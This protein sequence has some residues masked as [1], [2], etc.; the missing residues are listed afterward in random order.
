MTKVIPSIQK[1][2]TTSPHTI[3]REQLLSTA[4]ALMAKHRIRHLPVLDGG[5]LIGMITERDIAL[6][7]G[8]KDADLER[9]KVEDA[10]SP[11]PFS[12]QPESK[13]DEVAD[14]MAQYKYGSAVVT[15]HGKVVG[16]FTAVDALAA[17]AELLRSR[18]KN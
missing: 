12:V 7:S 4:Q 15:S 18:L 1:Y 6:V 3:G 14:E 16:I 8:L 2:M 13:L 5:A 10:M 17:F 11:V 9:L